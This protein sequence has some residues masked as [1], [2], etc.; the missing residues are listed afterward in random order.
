ML[1]Y[2]HHGLRTRTR[3][4]PSSLLGY[5]LGIGL[6][7]DGDRANWPNP[8]LITRFKSVSHDSLSHVASV[9]GRERTPFPHNGF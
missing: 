7:P 2:R 3:F 9:S 4:M 6:V 1:V 5:K 8:Y